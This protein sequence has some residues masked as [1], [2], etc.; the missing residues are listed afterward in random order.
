MSELWVKRVKGI[1]VSRCLECGDSFKCGHNSKRVTV[2][3]GAFRRLCRHDWKRV[4][5]VPTWRKFCVKCGG[6]TR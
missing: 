4:Y 1:L 6:M 2:R 3:T 5:T